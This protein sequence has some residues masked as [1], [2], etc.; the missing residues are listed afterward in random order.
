MPGSRDT[1]VNI[2]SLTKISVMFGSEEVKS[3]GDQNALLYQK[4]RECI[5]FT[6]FKLC[7]TTATH[8][9]KW[10]KITFSL[11]SLKDVTAD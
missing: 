5:I 9:L 2:V 10:V 7:L 1:G 8:N 6:N 11:K 3:S 4:R